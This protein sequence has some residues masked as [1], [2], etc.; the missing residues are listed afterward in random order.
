MITKIRVSNFYSIGKLIELDFYKGGNSI[1]DG[2]FNHKNQ[3]ISLLNGFYGA[4][5]SGKSNILKAIS[6]ILRLAYTKTVLRNDQKDITLVYDNFHNEFKGK[7]T[8]LGFDIL[9][10]DNYYKYD[11]E[12]HNR[13]SIKKETLF[14]INTKLKSAKSKKVFTRVNGKI[15]FGPEYKD[16]NSYFSVLK[17]AEYQTLLSHLIEGFRAGEEF[18]EFRQLKS[19][20]T[21]TAEHDEMPSV[22]GIISHAFRIST[23]EKNKKNEMLS[24]TKE[25]MSRFDNTIEALNVE[26]N[27]ASVKVSHSGFYENVDLMQESAGT[28]ELFAH[29]YNLLTVFKKG[30][31]VV[32]DETNLY[33]HPEIERSII[34]LFANKDVNTNNAQLFFASHNHETLDLLNLDQSFIV[35]KEKHNSTI[36]KISDIKE[37]K[38]RDNIKKKYR[39][40]ILGGTPDTIGFEHMIKQF[41]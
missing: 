29:I 21:K 33:F 20:F 12:I 39:M 14:V 18:N 35:E 30:G 4:N 26:S 7:P 25:I 6:T 3:K 22:F 34:S 9:L 1:E 40:G 13:K 37:I 32:Y 31:V 38:N 28:K 15:I 23:A 17:L 36:Y 24:L 11:I 16:H 8:K 27:S 5:A 10:N 41:L 19:W 2:Y